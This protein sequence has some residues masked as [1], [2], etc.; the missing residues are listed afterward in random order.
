MKHEPLSLH[1]IEIK[2]KMK[3][4]RLTNH[5]KASP[6]N[7]YAA[8][9]TWCVWNTELQ[10]TLPNNTDSDINWLQASF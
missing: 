4:A 9:I 2:K 3:T 6:Y 1:K 10:A 8:K 5:L 7:S